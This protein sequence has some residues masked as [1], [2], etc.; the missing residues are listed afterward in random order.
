MRKMSVGFPWK[1]PL[2]HLLPS[3]SH[4]PTL[5]LTLS[6]CF[7]PSFCGSLWRAALLLGIIQIAS[8]HRQWIKSL[9]RRS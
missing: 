3:L 2:R 5:P 1:L 8:R 4:P 6:I 7:L 9:K